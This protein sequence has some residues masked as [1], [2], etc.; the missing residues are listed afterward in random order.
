MESA[1]ISGD[2]LLSSLISSQITELPTHLTLKVCCWKC[3][4]VDGNPIFSKF[5]FFKQRNSIKA[6]AKTIFIKKDD[7]PTS[8]GKIFF[9]LEGLESGEHYVVFAFFVDRS[10]HEGENIP[11]VQLPLGWY[12]MEFCG[13]PT[14]IH[15]DV[16]KFHSIFITRRIIRHLSISTC[17]PLDLFN[18]MNRKQLQEGVWRRSK[19]SIFYNSKEVRNVHSLHNIQITNKGAMLMDIYAHLK[20]LIS[21]YI[22]FLKIEFNLEVFRIISTQIHI[23]R[24]ILERL[25]SFL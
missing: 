13:K 8:E 22:M 4:K 17:E 6:P 12:C 3:K 19:D 23:F 21:S 25:C 24:K 1:I 15:V 2:I 9:K 14:P 18:W 7:L 10:I 20:S 16:T 5:R 11:L